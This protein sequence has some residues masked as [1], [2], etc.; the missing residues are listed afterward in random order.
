MRHSNFIFITLIFFYSCLGP[1]EPPANGEQVVEEIPSTNRRD[2]CA[3]DLSD[4]EEEFELFRKWEFVG[5][6]DIANKKFDQLT[7]MARVA[8][9]ALSGED[10]DNVFQIMLEIKEV[11]GPEESGQKTGFHI[12][13]FSFE[14]AGLLDIDHEGM[15]F[16]FDTAATKTHPGPAFNTLPMLEFEG[17]LLKNLETAKVYQLDNNKLYLYTD[18]E[19]HR[20]VFLALGD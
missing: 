3:F 12:R 1:Q 4:V 17:R 16:L 6:Q 9:F 8:D 20:M 10:F 13:T 14:Y 19:S 15:T 5:F 7:C 18:S 11:D 2:F